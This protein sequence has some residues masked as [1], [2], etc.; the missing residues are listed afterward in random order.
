MK[1]KRKDSGDCTDPPFHG[2]MNR[3]N[4]V[5]KSALYDSYVL[6]SFI[7][8]LHGAV[9]YSKVLKSDLSLRTGS[10]RFMNESFGL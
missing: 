9:N 2:E 1:H 8:N 10:V 3:K 7:D 4:K 6:L 5:H